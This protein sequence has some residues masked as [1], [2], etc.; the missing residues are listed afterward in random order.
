MKILFSIAGLEF[1]G[2]E[3][4]I[5]RITKQLSESHRVILMNTRPD[6][7]NAQLIK[8]GLGDKVTLYTAPS[9]R[10]FKYIP[11]FKKIDSRLSLSYRT[12][13]LYVKALI[14]YYDIQL[15]CSFKYESDAFICSALQNTSIPVVVSTRGCYSLMK[16]MFEFSKPDLNYFITQTKNIFERANGLI[17]LTQ[18][19]IEVLQQS[20]AQVPAK[21]IQ[22]YNG[23]PSVAITHAHTRQESGISEHAKVFGMVARG[24]E[25]KGWRMAIEAF[26]LNEKRTDKEL[27]LILIGD[28]AFVQ[29]LKTTY[30]HERNIIFAGKIDN[31]V[32]YIPLFDVALLPTWFSGESIPNSIVEYLYC[33]KPVIATDWVEIPE[34]LSVNDQTAGF[35]IPLTGGCIPDQTKLADYMYT[36]IE[37]DDVLNEHTLLAQKA[38]DKFSMQVCAGKYSDFFQTMIHEGRSY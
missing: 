8:T 23:F 34:M 19:N 10:L 31:P 20:G 14:W 16:Q 7:S 3:V 33:G 24:I 13:K 15:V 22:I 9:K 28:S 25:E 26:L 1:G 38:F 4:F 21:N 5:L 36:Y 6:V 18:K 2:S 27:W 35:I 11:F 12:D 29:T 32:S 37:Y 30:A 17:W